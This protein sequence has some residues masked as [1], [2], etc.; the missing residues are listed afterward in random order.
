[1]ARNKK[2]VAE[3]TP[4]IVSSK[5]EGLSI[6]LFTYPKTVGLLTSKVA[7]VMML[8]KLKSDATV[9]NRRA[10]KRG[11]IGQMVAR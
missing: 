1:M 3:C 6:R 4:M 5:P 11:E 8:K 2:E 10:V 7:I 9:S